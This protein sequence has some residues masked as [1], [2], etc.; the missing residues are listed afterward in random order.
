GREDAPDP[1]I[2]PSD[3]STLTLQ[4]GEGGNDA[5]NA[6]YVD[7]SSDE[8]TAVE[9]DSWTLGFYTGDDFRVILNNQTGVAAMATGQS[10]ISDV[11]VSNTDLSQLT[12]DHTPENLSLYDDTLGR[13]E[14]T[15]IDEIKADE[16]DNQVYLLNTVHGSR[17]EAENVWKVKI[18]RNLDGGY[19]L[20]YAKLADNFIQTLSIQKDAVYNFSYVSLSACQVCGEPAKEDLDFVR[21]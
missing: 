12:Y 2:P 3:G 5:I 4:G 16:G 18:D 9:R 15:V 11:N 7:L 17:V 14:H 19:Q 6:V 10:D 1:I 21:Y 20:K 8:Q 13:L